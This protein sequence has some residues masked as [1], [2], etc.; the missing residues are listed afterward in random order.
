MVILSVLAGLAIPMYQANVERA[1]TAEA[2]QHLVETRKAMMQYYLNNDSYTGATIPL[3]GGGTL[4]FNPNVVLGGQV[5]IFRHDFAADPAA[6]TFTLRAT[7]IAE[8]G[9]AVPPPGSIR[10]NEAGDI[11]RTGV[12]L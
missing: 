12:Y 3:L 7:R 5:R 9:C 1:R 8:G 2:L 11:T 4:D 10:V 6:G